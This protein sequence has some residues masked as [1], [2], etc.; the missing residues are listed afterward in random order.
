M[1]EDHVLPTFAY[2]SSSQTLGCTESL[3]KLV[4]T[5]ITGP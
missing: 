2:G 3:E 4:K 5:Q 1:E